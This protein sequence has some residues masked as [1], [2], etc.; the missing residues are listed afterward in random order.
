MIITSSLQF[1]IGKVYN[2]DT[3]CAPFEYKGEEIWEY[4]FTVLRQVSESDFWKYVKEHEP[5]FADRIITR[6][7][8]YEIAID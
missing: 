8:F 1:E 4:A 7:Y 5:E 2:Q 3:L 6:T